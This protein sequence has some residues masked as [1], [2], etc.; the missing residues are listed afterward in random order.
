LTA[1]LLAIGFRRT[2]RKPKAKSIEKKAERGWREIARVL[3]GNVS[4][5]RV[6]AI[7]AGVTYFA[8]LAMFPF[9]AAIVAI[10]GLFGDPA[11][12]GAQLDQLSSFLPGG[13]LDVVGDQLK[14]AASGGKATLSLAF[15]VS[16]AI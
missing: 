14:R 10:Y 8:L 12:V 16:V 6:T 3:Y 5:H 15:L 2:E 4:E 11:A 13:A 7:A 1:G 9:I